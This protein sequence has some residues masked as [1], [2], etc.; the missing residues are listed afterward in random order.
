MSAAR[1]FQ[2]GDEVG[3]AGEFDGEMRSGVITTIHHIAAKEGVFEAFCAA[4]VE[5]TDGGPYVEP[6]GMVQVL[7]TADATAP[8]NERN[9]IELLDEPVGVL[10][11]E[12]GSVRGAL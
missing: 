3:A 5:V 12:P 1:P 6:S 4:Y 9:R 10:T 8:L 2:V 7:L 11:G